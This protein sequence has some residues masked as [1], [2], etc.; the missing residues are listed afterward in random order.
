MAKI[1][2]KCPNNWEQTLVK[3]DDSSGRQIAAQ[4]KAAQT[5]LY[6]F[7]CTS[8]LPVARKHFSNE[9]IG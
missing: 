6:S 9:K 8:C 5:H 2:P 7:L 4:L 3:A 1:F